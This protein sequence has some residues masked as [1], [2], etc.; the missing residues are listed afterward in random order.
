M[1]SKHFLDGLSKPQVGQLFLEIYKSL[2]GLMLIKKHDHELKSGGDTDVEIYSGILCRMERA[3][4]LAV[5]TAGHVVTM[6]RNQSKCCSGKVEFRVL[7]R[8]DCDSNS[9]GVPVRPCCSLTTTTWSEN[10]DPDYGCIAIPNFEASTILSGGGCAQVTQDTI[11]DEDEQFDAHFLIG[12][13][14]C[15]RDG[16][17]LRADMSKAELGKLLKCPL[18]PVTELEMDDEERFVAKI[19]TPDN[20]M[21]TSIVGMSGGPIWGVRK[22]SE[23]LEI[24]L[25]GIQSSWDERKKIIYAEYARD[26]VQKVDD[27]LYGVLVEGKSMNF[28]E[29]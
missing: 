10:G 14:K 2:V 15:V 8:G 4:I 22:K 1:K 5:L 28:E 25:V 12:F 23:Y 6:L 21:L 18:V 26:L 9:E 24:R 17:D 19:D 29:R 27:D 11:P 7:D 3:N 13:P 20:K 16:V